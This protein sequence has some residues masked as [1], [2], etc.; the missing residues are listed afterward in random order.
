M[1]R[2]EGNGLPRAGALSRSTQDLGASALARQATGVVRPFSRPNLTGNG[3]KLLAFTGIERGLKI[4][5]LDAHALPR[6]DHRLG[7]RTMPIEGLDLG[8]GRQF[9]P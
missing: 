9:A 1:G 7:L 3:L 8:R 2:A 6:G 5:T 4:R